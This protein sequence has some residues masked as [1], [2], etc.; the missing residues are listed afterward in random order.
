MTQVLNHTTMSHNHHTELQE[1][2][3]V[4]T[5]ATMPTLEQNSTHLQPKINGVCLLS[6]WRIRHSGS[7]V[8]LCTAAKCHVKFQMNSKENQTLHLKVYIPISSIKAYSMSPLQL[9]SMVQSRKKPQNQEFQ[10]R[11]LHTH[12][13]FLI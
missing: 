12:L 5:T 6:W 13:I 10:F 4:I 3:N 2:G 9:H 8:M 11:I 7:L 1:L